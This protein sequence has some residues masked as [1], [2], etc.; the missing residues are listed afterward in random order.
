[1]PKSEI[2]NL[3]DELPPERRAAAAAELRKLD[4]AT[5][6]QDERWIADTFAKLRRGFDAS[7]GL[8]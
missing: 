5:E 4:L 2:E 1:M 8:V 3:L 7:K 6:A